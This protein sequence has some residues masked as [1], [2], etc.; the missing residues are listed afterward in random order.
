MTVSD[1]RR[2]AP[3]ILPRAADLPTMSMAVRPASSA[4][5]VVTIGV[6]VD[7]P[8]PFGQEL[9][10]RR[11]EF[12]DPLARAIPTHITLLPPTDV[13][14]GIG[15]LVSDHLAAVAAATAPFLVRLRGTGSFR[16]VSPVVFVRLDEGAEGCDTLQRMIR[17]GPLSRELSF[18]FHPHVTV[19]QN[20]DET[21]LDL[22]L[23]TLADYQAEFMVTGLGLY[24]H[25]RDGVW[26]QRH[27]FPFGGN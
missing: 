6:V 20:L 13:A 12:G 22:A 2:D 14:P 19:A 18:P 1:S 24:E 26:R 8:E 10:S 11:A 9:R 17:T 23:A 21:A 4:D 27:R 3:V 7:V 15:G 5:D 16:P 25:G